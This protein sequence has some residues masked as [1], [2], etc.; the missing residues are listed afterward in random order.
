MHMK[1]RGIFPGH[2][3]FGLQNPVLIQPTLT[4]ATTS[5]SYRADP[6]EQKTITIPH[7]F[8]QIYSEKNVFVLALAGP[9]EET[10]K[11]VLL[12]GIFVFHP[13]LFSAIETKS[14]CEKKRISI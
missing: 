4:E 1:N 6:P 13:R 10:L 7:I 14:Q 5:R 8:I 11:G 2:M 3:N 9:T 12:Y